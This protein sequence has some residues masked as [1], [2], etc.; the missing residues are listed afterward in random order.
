MLVLLQGGG[1][2]S[3]LGLRDDAIRSVIMARDIVPRAFSCDYALVAEL[4]RSWG[5]SWRDHNC[6]SGGVDGEGAALLHTSCS[7]YVGSVDPHAGMRDV[8]LSLDTSASLGLS[9]V[10]QV[11]S[12]R[13][14][15]WD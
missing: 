5:P 1:L 13:S 4:L 15:N 10:Y 11:L 8:Q 9:G 6:L 14:N 2:L 3:R 12:K 7:L